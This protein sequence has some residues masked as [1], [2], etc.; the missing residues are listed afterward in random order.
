MSH[1]GIHKVG[2]V[3][4]ERLDGESCGIDFMERLDGEFRKRVM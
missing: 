1:E 3:L 2:S 4:K